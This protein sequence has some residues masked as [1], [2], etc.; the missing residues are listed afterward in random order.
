MTTIVGVETPYR[1]I[2]AADRQ[3][4]QGPDKT[5]DGVKIA[6]NGDYTFAAAGYLRSIQVLQYASLPPIPNT[7][8]RNF[9]DHEHLE[10]D[11]FFTREIIPAVREAFEVVDSEALEESQLLVAVKNRL[12]NVSGGCGAW[13]RSRDGLYAVGSGAPYAMGA[14]AV[15][16]SPEAAIEIAGEYDIGTSGEVL[17]HEI[18]F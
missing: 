10:L 9:T 1:T 14:L 15:G 8:S 18:S 3:V 12:Y 7:P 11:R 13:L 16:A 5:T 2:L 6:T 4:T 17:V